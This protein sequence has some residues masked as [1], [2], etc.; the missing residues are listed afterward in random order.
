M[1]HK[2]RALELHRRHEVDSG[3]YQESTFVAGMDGAYTNLEMPKR[4]NKGYDVGES[5]SIGS[6]SRLGGRGRT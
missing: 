3:E 2:K 4:I 5:S 6:S 1:R